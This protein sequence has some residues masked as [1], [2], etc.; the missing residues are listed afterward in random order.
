MDTNNE[1][2]QD[3]HCETEQPHF[4]YQMSEKVLSEE[5]NAPENDIWDNY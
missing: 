4:C 2:A 3:L 5:W 1:Q